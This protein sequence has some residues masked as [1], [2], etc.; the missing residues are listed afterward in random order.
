MSNDP[1]LSY[2]MSH[3]MKG[4]DEAKKC[5]EEHEVEEIRYEHNLEDTKVEYECNTCG[6]K[7]YLSYTLDRVSIE[8]GK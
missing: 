7:I 8:E 1:I 6:R 4:L 2:I 5:F 3:K